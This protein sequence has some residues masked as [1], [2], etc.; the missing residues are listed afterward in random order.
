MNT[1]KTRVKR[2]LKYS[3]SA[4]I[5]VVLVL[6]FM[7]MFFNSIYFFDQTSYKSGVTITLFL[8]VELFYTIVGF[9]L[10]FSLDLKES[11]KNNC[12]S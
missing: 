9:I 3:V 5:S 8:G 1:F 10:G 4:M 2:G 7:E 6:A 11:F 12:N